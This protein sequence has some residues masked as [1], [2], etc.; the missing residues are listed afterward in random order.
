MH[1]KLA[2]GAA[3]GIPGTLHRVQALLGWGGQIEGLTYTVGRHVPG[4]LALSVAACRA[5]W[6]FVDSTD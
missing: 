3:V 4:A 1:A 6:L 2:A 5:V